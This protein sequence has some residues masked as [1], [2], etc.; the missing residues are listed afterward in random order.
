MNNKRL[1]VNMAASIV[2]F[3]VSFGISFFLSPYLIANLGKEAYGFFSLG[4]QF[5]SYA[6]IVASALNSMASRFVTIAIHRGDME[7]RN[8]YFSSVIIANIFLSLVLL[9]PSVLIVL[10]L[11]N[12]LFVPSDILLDVKLLWALIFLNFL[13]TIITNAYGIATFAANK[14]YLSSIRSMESGLFKALILVG[15]FGLFKPELWFL[16]LASVITTIYTIAFNI[17][18]TKKLF[19]DLS[20]QRKYFDI[21]SVKELLSSGIWNSF[22]QLAS[23]LNNG[24]DLLIANLF[25][26]SAAMG[27]LSITKVFPTYLAQIIALFAATFTPEFAKNYAQND[28]KSLLENIEFARCIMTIISTIPVVILIVDGNLFF[29]LWVP[30][31]NSREL[32]IISASGLFM[33]LFVGSLN[34]VGDVILLVNRQ[35]YVAVTYFIAGILN[36]GIVFFLLRYVDNNSVVLF[37]LSNEVIKL[38]IVSGV[39]GVIAIIRNLLFT[40]IYAAKCLNE[41]WCIF[42]PVMIKGMLSTAI[43][44]ISAYIIKSLIRSQSWIG[45]FANALIVAVLGVIINGFILFDRKKLKRLLSKLMRKE[46]RSGT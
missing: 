7:K 46:I 32:Q 23:V 36:V 17:Y 37:G 29:K 22:T 8:K 33:Y 12:L 14:L 40:P 44:F 20:C 21:K 18:Y 24:L 10:F 5:V 1:A 6:S 26:S 16:G 13:I 3:I 34:T 35:K 2:N 43:T 42:Y 31:S 4:N 28:K 25:I 9:I 45:F 38:L 39:S 30:S 19:P 15:M 11:E 27:T 41:K